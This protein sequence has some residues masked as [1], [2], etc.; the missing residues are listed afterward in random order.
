MKELNDKNEA[1]HAD[2]DKRE[3]RMDLA[4]KKIENQDQ[5]IKDLNDMIRAYFDTVCG[6]IIW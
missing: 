2:L 4:K 1:L 3:K 6:F 5:K